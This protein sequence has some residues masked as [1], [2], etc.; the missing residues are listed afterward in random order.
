M[1]SSEQQID[2]VTT[3]GNLVIAGWIIYGD[4]G[5]SPL[6]VLNAIINGRAI[7][8]LLIIEVFPV[9][10]DFNTS[11]DNKYVWLTLNADNKGARNILALCSC[12]AS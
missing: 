9:L 4:I 12:S 7:S 3:L 1:H 10:S 11:N 5:T 6:Y 2:K 8:E